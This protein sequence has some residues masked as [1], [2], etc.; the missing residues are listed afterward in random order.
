L[1]AL[2]YLFNFVVFPGFLFL[3]I[4]GFVVSWVDRKVS[5]RVQWRVGPPIY[6]PLV[7]FI[8]L[9]GKEVIVPEK[10]SAVVFLG[11][12]LIGLAGATLAGTII[13]LTG[14][15]GKGFVGDLIVV[16]YLLLIPSI[17]IIIGGSASRNPLS[18]VGASREMT[19]MLA[20]ELPFIMALLVPVIKSGG[21]LRLSVLAA[22]TPL[23]SI[24]GV[25]ACIVALIALQAKLTLVPFDIP[26]AETE[27]MAGPFVEYSGAPLGVFK[28]MHE[29]LF[30][31]APGFLTLVFWGGLN[32]WWAIPKI[33]LFLVLF[34]L[35][36]NTNPRLRIDQALKFF[37][38]VMA[39]LAVIALVLA[40]YGL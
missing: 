28:L 40:L 13:Y 2:G 24:S 17:A 31:V 1:S 27:I 37:W 4:M 16:I 9:L 19:L 29:I 3:S 39:S 11:A 22:N 15:T 5:A 38:I 7:D 14:L 30:F 35:I 21:N 34:I 10:T 8:K 23:Y 32:S 18:S 6:Q 12:P 36:K 33:V 26:E 25:I 20:Y